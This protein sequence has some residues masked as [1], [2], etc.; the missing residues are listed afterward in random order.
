M[1][2]AM[3]LCFL[4]VTGIIF[5]FQASIAQ[6]IKYST[7]P[8]CINNNVICKNSNEIPTCLVLNSKVHIETTINEAGEKTNRFQPSCKNQFNDLIPSCFDLNSN[9]DEAPGGVVLECIEFVKCNSDEK[10]NKVIAN[11]SG[12]K[13]PKCLGNNDLPNCEVE[14]VCKNNS[15]PVCD[16]IW[17]ASAA[18]NRG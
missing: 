18:L 10:S 7:P 1:W 17:E 12:G 6:E 11:C 3:R 5:T 2:W 8:V 13:V 15:I 9:L 16:Y 14:D 4:L